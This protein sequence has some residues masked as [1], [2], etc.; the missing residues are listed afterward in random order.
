MHVYSTIPTLRGFQKPMMQTSSASLA[1][2]TPHACLLSAAASSTL[3][4]W[5]L[6]QQPHGSF[7]QRQLLFYEGG[8]LHI[9]FP[10]HQFLGI[11]GC[12]V[13]WNGLAWMYTELS[14]PVHMH[15]R[16]SSFHSGLRNQRQR[17]Q[18]CDS[19]STEV[20]GNESSARKLPPR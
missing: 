18:I 9:R 11:F 20:L 10:G 6:P 17:Q 15:R 13:C 4:I 7:T 8:T 3:V 19:C 12:L 1:L 14:I 16:S 2:A 5:V